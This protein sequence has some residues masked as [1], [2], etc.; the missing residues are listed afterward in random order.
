VL[1]RTGHNE[2][3]LCV[4]RNIIPEFVADDLYKA[5][6]EHILALL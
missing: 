3:A 2:E 6:T 5:V 4:T 1:V